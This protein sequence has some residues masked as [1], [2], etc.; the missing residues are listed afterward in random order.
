MTEPQRGW[1][2]SQKDPVMPELIQ[3]SEADAASYQKECVFKTFFFELV[4]GSL[5]LLLLSRFSRV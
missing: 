1:R 3:W 5:L 2:V 4:I